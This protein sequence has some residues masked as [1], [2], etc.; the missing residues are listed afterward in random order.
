[1]GKPLKSKIRIET[2]EI[3]D[4]DYPPNQCPKCNSQE[5]TRGSYYFRDLQELGEPGVA[6]RIRY[7]SVIWIC[8]NCKTS[9]SIKHPDIP[10][11]S[12]YMPSVITYTTTRI[13]QKGDPARRVTN[14]LKE[15]HNVDI[16]L[17]TV[18][19]WVNKDGNR[20]EIPVEFTEES[21]LSDFSGVL[22]VDG[23][24]KSVKAKKNEQR[25]EGNV[26]PFLHLTHLQDGRLVAYWQEEK[27]KKKSQHSSKN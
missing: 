18:L 10:Y 27:M 23:T 11:R 17:G 9:F 21:P 3:S 12:S 13:L 1:M 16:S 7:E 2:R 26:P 5:F 6:R 24:F 4:A 20:K 25:G 14:D 22:G 15:L 19:S 8:K